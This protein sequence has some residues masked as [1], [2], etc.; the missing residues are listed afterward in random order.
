MDSEQVIALLLF[1]ILLIFGYFGERVSQSKDETTAAQG[2]RIY[3]RA[4]KTFVFLFVTIVGISMIFLSSESLRLFSESN[5][6]RKQ[7]LIRV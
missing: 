5:C 1:L 6:W 2:R 3:E 7:A 4:V